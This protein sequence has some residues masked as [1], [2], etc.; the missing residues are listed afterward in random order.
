MKKLLI[1]MMLVSGLSFA[2]EGGNGGGAF[3]C[4]NNSGEII[5]A[6]LVDLYE[7]N[8]QYGL[9]VK[10][11]SRLTLD[12]QI[13][14]ASFRIR[15]ASSE[16]YSNLEP[17]LVKIREIIQVVANAK[18]ENTNDFDILI[19]P[20]SCQGGKVKFE[21]LANYT[22]EGQLII[23]KEIWSILPT[24]D[25]A[26]LYL[27]ESIYSLLRTEDKVVTSRRARQIT[28]YAFSNPSKSSFEEL[29]GSAIIS[30]VY[31]CESPGATFIIDSEYPLLGEKKPTYLLSTGWCFTEL[32][33]CSVEWDYEIRLKA[34][35]I[36]LLN[37]E[38]SAQ[39]THYNGEYKTLS[40]GRGILKRLADGTVILEFDSAS[41]PLIGGKYDQ[42][43]V[44]SS[45]VNPR[46]W[47]REKFSGCRRTRSIKRN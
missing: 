22:N 18:L 16:F 12:E 39:I 47:Y 15:N 4:R 14:L 30:G 34:N 35:N 9:N 6:E 45:L 2:K 38:V 37:G 43:Q 41:P 31:K 11:S 40:G 3:V 23:D 29:L 17:H 25:K 28:A 44:K 19:S 36:N 10:K 42:S 1:L 20:K 7:A 24:T 5:S 21:Q 46:W 27:H 32:H 33:T 26:A 13:D 8:A